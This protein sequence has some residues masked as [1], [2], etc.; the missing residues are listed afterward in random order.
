MQEKAH[1]GTTS[2]VKHLT[3]FQ[4]RLRWPKGQLYP[5]SAAAVTYLTDPTRVA[6]LCLMLGA[7]PLFV[8]GLHGDSDIL[9]D[10]PCFE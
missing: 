3:S 10:H 4:P 5:K 1:L 6:T 7:F 2:E 8:K 9:H